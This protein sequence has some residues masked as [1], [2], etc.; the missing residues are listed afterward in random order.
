MGQGAARNGINILYCMALTRHMLQSLEIENI[1]SFRASDDYK[2]GNGQWQ[3]GLTSAWI[4]AVG[5]APFK[6]MFI[7][8]PDSASDI[9][10]LQSFA[11]M[12]FYLI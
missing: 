1:V 10:W 4:H 11:H 8:F 3:I 6:G 9:A 12:I 2:P 5:L 7:E